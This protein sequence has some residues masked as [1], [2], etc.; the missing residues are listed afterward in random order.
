MK[1][2]RTIKKFLKI[3]VGIAAIG[4]LAWA[5]FNYVNS[6]S[7][8]QKN[9]PF[10]T[11]L[12]SRGDLAI[13]ISSTGS[14]A[15]RGTVEVGTQVSGTIDTIAVD[16]NDQVKKGQTLATLNQAL[17][18]AEV[19]AAK[20]SVSKAKAKLTQARDKWPGPLRPAGCRGR[21]P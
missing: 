9:A 4:L 20:A 11:A 17:F 6:V 2:V 5:G 1:K 12:L 8:S 16:F 15:A 14:L 19:L 10:E 3:L 7:A 21:W 18:K 13:T